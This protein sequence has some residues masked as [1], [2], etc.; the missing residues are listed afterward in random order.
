MARDPASNTIRIVTR[1][2]VTGKAHTV[3]TWF[4]CMEDVV[5]VAARRG[6]RS[7]WLR[8]S[9]AAPVVELRRRRQLWEVVAGL[10][11]DD[12]ETTRVIDAFAEKY[13]RHPAIISAWRAD[14]PTFV[15]FRD[16][17]VHRSVSS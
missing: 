13:A 9:L 5:Y 2:R 17:W 12:E 4:V 11:H 16:R 15:R 8:N 6:L 7:D 14:P 3:S 10:V 1:G